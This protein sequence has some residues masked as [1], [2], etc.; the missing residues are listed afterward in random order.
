MD[1]YNQKSFRAEDIARLKKLVD[2]GCQVLQ[3]VDDLKVGLSETV[4]A[5]AEEIEVKPTQLNKA[6]KIAYKASMN[7]EREKLDEIEDL[8]G[9][10]G[11]V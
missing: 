5:I 9:A 7:E 4:K 8:L 10:A 1:G 2:E 11:R 6:I 3:E